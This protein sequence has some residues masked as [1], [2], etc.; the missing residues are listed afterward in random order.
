[1]FKSHSC[2]FVDISTQSIV[3]CILNTCT[4]YLSPSSMLLTSKHRG[5]MAEW[6]K[7]LVQG[8]SHFRGLGSSPTPVNFLIFLYKV[9]FLVF[10]TP[11]YCIF[12]HNPCFRPHN[13]QAGLPSGL[14]PWFKAPFTFMEWVCVQLQSFCWHS[15]TK[16][17][18]LYFEPLHIIS[19]TIILAIDQEIY[20]QDGRGV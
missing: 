11:A 3:S 8:T 10:C 9:Y 13:I 19:F 15:Y 20:R 14:R 4:W 6:S 16:L 18:F 5:R 17:S 7:S 2:H 1:M 12:F